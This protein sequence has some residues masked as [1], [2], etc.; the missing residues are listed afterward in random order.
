ME[1]F[2]QSHPCQSLSWLPTLLSLSQNEAFCAENEKRKKQVQLV[3]TFP[4]TFLEGPSTPD[5]STPRSHTWTFL[6]SHIQYLGLS[7][8]HS[9][10]QI[11]TE[12]RLKWHRALTHTNTPC[13][14][15]SHRITTHSVCHPRSGGSPPATNL[16]IK[17]PNISRQHNTPSQSHYNLPQSP[18]SS[19]LHTSPPFLSLH[20]L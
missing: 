8:S 19:P 6:G 2:L 14:C 18:H 9:W 1:Y 4:S 16:G 20:L 7:H 5:T 10:A 15:S 11:T 13:C 17:I 3:K 12:T